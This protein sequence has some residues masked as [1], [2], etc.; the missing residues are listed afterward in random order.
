[1]DVRQNM[2]PLDM[3]HADIHTALA[4]FVEESNLSFR[5]LFVEE[6]VKPEGE[7]LYSA[8]KGPPRKKRK[9]SHC[10][11]HKRCSCASMWNLSSIIMPCLHAHADY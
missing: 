1:M 10:S 5:T 4:A 3:A 8:E 2:A 6:C 9:V 7:M 11:D